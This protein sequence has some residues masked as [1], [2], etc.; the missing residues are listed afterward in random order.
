MEWVW[1]ESNGDTEKETEREREGACAGTGWWDGI[2][3]DF[4]RSWSATSSPPSH[5]SKATTRHRSSL[6]LTHTFTICK[7]THTCLSGI[8]WLHTDTNTHTRAI[9]WLIQAH[10]N[11]QECVY[12][13]IYT[14]QT[15]QP[16]AV[17]WRADLRFIFL[18]CEYPIGHVAKC[19]CF[20][21]T[22]CRKTKQ[23]QLFL[24]IKPENKPVVIF[25]YIPFICDIFT[26]VLKNKPLKVAWKYTRCLIYY[27]TIPLIVDIYILWRH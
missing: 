12:T 1:R 9:N 14:A 26:V 4:W 22:C 5:P 15:V 7:H 20:W 13:Y 18:R 23:Q 24:T 10:P 17:A 16:V 27:V 25:C 21:F 6:K 11:R 2:L 19:K 3:E 8:S